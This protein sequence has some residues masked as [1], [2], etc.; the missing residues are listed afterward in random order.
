VRL[1]LAEWTVLA[2]IAERPV[3]GFAIAAL[4]AGDGELGRI[5][6]I[7]RPVVYR[8]LGRLAEAELIT[9]G[10]VESGPGPQRTTYSATAAGRR[11]AADWLRRPV[12][13]V[14]E[15][16]SYLLIKLALLGRRGE[17]PA[18][19]LGAQRAVLEPIAAAVAAERARSSGFDAVL[20]AWRESM[21]AAALAFLDQVQ[22]TAAAPRR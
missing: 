13:H 6:Q 19:L 8:A 5:W 2:V 10:A 16:R 3:H 21:T 17:D 12:R 15:I 1:G 9:A 22:P 14:R 4:T 7:P 18:E 20:L 11:A